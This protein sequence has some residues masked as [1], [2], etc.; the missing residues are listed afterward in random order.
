MRKSTDEK[1]MDTFHAVLGSFSLV[2]RKQIHLSITVGYQHSSELKLLYEFTLKSTNS[3]HP[4]KIIPQHLYNVQWN[5]LHTLLLL[6]S[7]V[8]LPQEIV[9]DLYFVVSK[10]L[11]HK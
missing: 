4:T 6:W 8:K 7:H 1:N 9:P 11:L 5:S 2:K 3:F 10:I